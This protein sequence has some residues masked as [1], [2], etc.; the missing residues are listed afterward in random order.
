M[1]RDMNDR[2]TR[3][4]VLG[5][6]L[7]AAILPAVMAG[8]PRFAFAQVSSSAPYLVDVPWLSGQLE[9]AT[10]D[11]LL[12]DVSDLRPYRSAH[13]PGAIHSYWLETIERNYE[14]YGT[15]LD[16]LDA[17]SEIENQGKRIAWLRRH[18][19]SANTHVVAYDR[20]DA[21]RAARIVWF[22]RF[23]GHPHASLLDG[24]FSAWQQAGMATLSGAE[25]R[26][27]ATETAPVAPQAGFYLA[28]DRLLDELDV[29]SVVLVDVRNDAERHDTIDG[30]FETGE[31]P[32]GVR[33]P[34]DTDAFSLVGPE[35]GFDVST[36]MAE[37]EARGIT[38][39][40]RIVLYGRFGSD[41]NQMWVVFKEC[42]FEQVEIYD[43]G[44]IEWSA[45]GQPSQPIS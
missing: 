32:G 19:I 22:L 38:P 17:D 36:A 43:R 2:L 12:M 33:V 39:G 11:L 40:Q 21:R 6:S 14:F 3:R 35:A 44:W 16:Q 28:T 30:Q 7:T 5:S 10:P 18:G 15:V 45:T 26:P 41:C 29:E 25:S 13:I 31:I 20:T 37:L 23:L 24:G 34:W 8:L 4:H 1:I 42:G 27:T 9:I